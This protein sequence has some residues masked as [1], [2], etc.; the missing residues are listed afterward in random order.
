MT[1]DP[2]ELTFDLPCTP[3][4][5]FAAWTEADRITRWWGEAGAYRT[6]A[7]SADLR[8]GGAWRAEFEGAGGETFSAE[9]RYATAEP[10]DRL[11]WSWR[12]SWAP[13]SESLVDMR[14]APEGDATRL[15]IVQTGFE[16][17]ERADQAEGWRQIV[18]WL[19]A[20]L[21]RGAA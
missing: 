21:T 9:G 6:T 10:P 17:G 3:A 14:F 1:D 12:A 5:A 15:Q 20:D 2:L 8:A 18:G 4:A 13:E 11:V 16:E 7:W 19:V